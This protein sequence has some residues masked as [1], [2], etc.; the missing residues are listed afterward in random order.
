MLMM[1]MTMIMMILIIITVDC[2]PPVQL[3]PR[4]Q[5]QPELMGC[6]LVIMMMVDD[7]DD[8]EYVDNACDDVNDDVGDD[9]GV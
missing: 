3:P 1:M 2:L 7:G 5:S 9:A 6:P 8:G 4:S